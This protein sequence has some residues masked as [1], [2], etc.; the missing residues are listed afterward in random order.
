MSM[1]LYL[2][3]SKRKRC[4][5]EVGQKRVEWVQSVDLHRTRRWRIVETVGWFGDHDGELTRS[6]DG[7]YEPGRQ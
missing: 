1:D 4:L 6:E 3:L 5:V 2:D 7:R